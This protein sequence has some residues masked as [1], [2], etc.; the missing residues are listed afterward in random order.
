ML[1]VIRYG[2]SVI[3]DFR[4]RNN[5]GKWKA[6]GHRKGPTR[7]AAFA[8]LEE[9]TGHTSATEFMSRPRDG[10]TRN[11]DLFWRRG[12]WAPVIAVTSRS[13]PA[14]RPPD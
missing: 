14:T 1:P 2:R 6:L 10:H 9:L 7:D 13:I 5:E 11:W 3:F 12:E 4:Y 8:S